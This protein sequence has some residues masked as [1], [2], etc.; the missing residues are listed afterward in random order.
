M[1]PRGEPFESELIGC[2]LYIIIISRC[3]LKLLF[4]LINGIPIVGVF[5]ETLE[6]KGVE[7]LENDWKT[8]WSI[9]ANKIL[10]KDT[11]MMSFQYQLGKWFK[12]KKGMI[13]LPL[14]LFTRAA[15]QK[16]WFYFTHF[17]MDLQQIDEVLCP[18]VDCEPVAIR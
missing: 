2:H 6:T 15:S 14:L 9:R 5:N 17:F 1:T 7:S 13:F 12:L 4:D 3:I 16:I 8:S 11:M 10:V 18:L